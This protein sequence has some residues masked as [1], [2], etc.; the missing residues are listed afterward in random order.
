MLDIVS[1]AT[2][3]CFPPEFSWVIKQKLLSEKCTKGESVPY[4]RQQMEREMKCQNA[5]RRA[6]NKPLWFKIKFENFWEPV[7]SFP[8]LWLSEPLVVGSGAAAVV[9]GVQQPPQPDRR[10][11]DSLSTSPRSNPAT[12]ITTMTSCTWFGYSA[13]GELD[14]WSVK[15]SDW[16]K[17]KLQ[18]MLDRKW[19]IVDK[20]MFYPLSRAIQAGRHK[21]SQRGHLVHS[22][23]QMTSLRNGR[24]CGWV[25]TILFITANTNKND[26]WC[27]MYPCSSKTT[28]EGT[29]KRTSRA[30]RMD[31]PKPP[32]FSHH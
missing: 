13:S 15:Q 9:P 4:T 32:K 14:C 11:G 7:W 1:D 31:F 29:A 5:N 23:A 10:R 27:I 3:T 6:V 18:F 21:S 16:D 26:Y 24:G 8:F 22:D 12:I 20:C 25:R 19:K 30:E 28:D 2:L 17:R